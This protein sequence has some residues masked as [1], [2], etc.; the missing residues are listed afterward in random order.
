MVD[1]LPAGM[2]A[3][4]FFTRFVSLFQAQADTLVAHADNL[5]HLVDP[6]VAPPDM[7]RWMAGWIGQDGLDP[8]LAVDLQRRM[9][10]TTARTLPWRGTLRGLRDVL[11]LFSGA[12]AH[13]EDGG[14]VWREGG[15]PPD[16][17]WVIM[18]VAG[19]GGLS[20]ADFVDLVA[21]EVPAHVRA[22]LWIG[23]RLVWP[24]AGPGAP[25]EAATPDPPTDA[26]PHRPTPAPGEAP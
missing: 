16:T 25:P 2:L 14:G 20:E 21:D 26:A 23:D 18:R 8:G 6:A 11:T 1:Q 24:V 15:A 17:A 9:L 5:E 4:D 7:V 19:T 13:V 10:V 22:E 12:P 3:D